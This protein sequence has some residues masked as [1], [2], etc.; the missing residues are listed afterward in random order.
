MDQ[1][2]YANTVHFLHF[3]LGEAHKIRTEKYYYHK[4]CNGDEGY[5]FPLWV[6]STE[7]NK[8]KIHFYGNFDAFV[9]C[10]NI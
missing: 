7:V 8:Y 6:V 3:P 4:A 1:F 5:T 9:V 2:Q 10:S